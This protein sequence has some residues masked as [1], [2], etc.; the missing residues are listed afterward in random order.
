M[1][2]ATFFHD[3]VPNFMNFL[4]SGLVL[5]YY[6][7]VASRWVFL[8]K[9]SVPEYQA[10]Y[11]SVCV[12]YFC[13]F[14]LI[15]LFYFV[16]LERFSQQWIAEKVWNNLVM[17]EIMYTLYVL[18]LCHYVWFKLLRIIMSSQI[19]WTINS[20]TCSILIYQNAKGM[21]WWGRR[22][23]RNKNWK[24]FVQKKNLGYHKE[25]IH[26]SLD[27]VTLTSG[28]IVRHNCHGISISSHPFPVYWSFF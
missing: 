2:H 1:E 5:Y 19:Q 24:A 10:W 12:I 15:I 27:Y 23:S 25:K 26:S 3:K 13:V 16:A 18:S 8:L 9:E 11:T 7:Y 22:K 6:H 17:S 21:T 28:P 14:V 4:P 20:S